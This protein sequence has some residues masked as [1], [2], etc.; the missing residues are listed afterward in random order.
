MSSLDSG[1]HPHPSWQ[2]YLETIII[3][4]CGLFDAN[5][6]GQ[7][8]PLNSLNTMFP[9][10][11][12]KPQRAWQCHALRASRS[13]V[14]GLPAREKKKKTLMPQFHPKQAEL[15]PS[16]DQPAWTMS[17]YSLTMWAKT[18]ASPWGPGLYK[19]I[20]PLCNL[21]GWGGEGFPVRVVVQFPAFLG[22]GI[23][24]QIFYSVK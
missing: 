9:K 7:F 11:M 15:L 1:D 14:L 23:L 5:S 12:A 16:K 6:S 3:S 2:L 4:Q 13:E 24:E 20:R 19:N 8:Y 10:E 17:I 22:V 18:E 21:G